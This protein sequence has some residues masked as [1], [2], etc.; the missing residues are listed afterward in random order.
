MQG[1]GK[2]H[3]TKQASRWDGERGAFVSP[4]CRETGDRG[5]Q[6]GKDKVRK[7]KKRESSEEKTSDM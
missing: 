3:C 6:G 1:I 5:R 2:G 7:R 4:C